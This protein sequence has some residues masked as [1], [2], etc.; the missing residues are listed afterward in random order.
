M[1]PVP[2]SR[3]GFGDEGAPGA[4]GDGRGAGQEPEPRAPAL[5]G[6]KRGGRRGRKAAS[7]GGRKP[8]SGA[9]L[10]RGS[11]AGRATAGPCAWR[12][13]CALCA[14]S[15]R[16]RAG[17]GR[18]PGCRSQHPAA[19]ARRGLSLRAAAGSAAVLARGSQ[20]S[21]GG[22]ASRCVLSQLRSPPSPSALPGL[23]K[24]PGPAPDGDPRVDFSLEHFFLIFFISFF[25]P[26]MMQQTWRTAP[27]LSPPRQPQ[28]FSR[29]AGVVEL[30]PGAEPS[31]AAE[32]PWVPAGCGSCRPPG[33]RLDS[34][35]EDGAVKYLWALLEPGG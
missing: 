19:P 1:C 6:R 15:C 13:G 7:S 27:S 21:R 25:S 32:G 10:C 24:C 29:G 14:A 31:E 35:A 12:T 11:C 18:A 5:E 28:S 26:E 16:E 20:Q 33:C 9:R 8:G 2:S 30:S 3:A 23:G 34:S 17:P 22:A 4:A